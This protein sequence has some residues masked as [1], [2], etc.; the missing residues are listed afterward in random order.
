MG[1]YFKW[2]AKMNIFYIIG[3][4]V[5]IGAIFGFIQFQ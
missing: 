3:V 2:R 4:V 1:R 5:V